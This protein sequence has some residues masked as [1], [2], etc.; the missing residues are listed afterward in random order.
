VVD[1][2][3]DVVDVGR[4]SRTPPRRMRRAL[5]IRDETCC[6]PGCTATRHLQSHHIVHW[7]HGGPTALS[8][9]GLV[10]RRHHRL[11][12]EGGFGLEVTADGNRRFYRPDGTEIAARGPSLSGSDDRLVDG[13]RGNGVAITA[14]TCKSRW[15]GWR[16]DTTYVADV[17]CLEAA[18]HDPG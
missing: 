17:L 7:S 1:K 12:H 5:E 3:G 11:V 6:W 13:N 8:N 18:K 2:D 14:E 15:D 9:L 4:S 16:I 10:C